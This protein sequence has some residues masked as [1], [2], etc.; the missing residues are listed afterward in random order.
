MREY[1][2][3]MTRGSYVMGD[4]SPYNVLL[5]RRLI[6]NNDSRTIKYFRS[7]ERGGSCE[8]FLPDEYYKFKKEHFKNWE[9]R[10]KNSINCFIRGFHEY[11]F[12]N[13]LTG[14]HTMD[15][16]D[17]NSVGRLSSPIC[18]FS[19]DYRRK[20][21]SSGENWNF[22]GFLGAVK[23]NI[24][25]THLA[26][27]KNATQMHDHFDTIRKRLPRRLQDKLSRA[28]TS[29]YEICVRPFEK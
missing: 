25:M 1:R 9:Q 2:D 26:G 4:Q 7:F 29:V 15:A 14:K 27:K 18:L 24:F 13:T 8:I 20:D 3:A 17:H 21:H 10:L 22:S 6:T 19:S 5:L 12:N 23:Y 28:N 16:L 11:Y